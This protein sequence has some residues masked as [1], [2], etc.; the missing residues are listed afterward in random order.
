MKST[1]TIT[2]YIPRVMQIA[3]NM[4]IHGE[5]LE[6]GAIVEKILRSLTEKYNYIACSIAESKDTYK[7]SVD[8]VHSSLMD[9][10][11]NYLR[12][13]KNHGEEQ[14]LE[15]EVEE[16]LEV[17]EEEDNPVILLSAINARNWDITEM[18]ALSGY[19]NQC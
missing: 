11:Q 10:K 13:A 2:D 12:F 17:E 15:L 16:V 8:E 9:H 5:R 19:R 14:A 18:N 1:E 3:N 6:D 7:M 4:R